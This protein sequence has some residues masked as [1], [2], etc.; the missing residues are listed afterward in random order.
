MPL[1]LGWVLL[2]PIVFPCRYCLDGYSC[3]PVCMHVLRF[4]NLRASIELQSV[5]PTYACLRMRMRASVCVCVPPYAYACLHSTY[6]A[7]NSILFKLKLTSVSTKLNPSLSLPRFAFLCLCL[8]LSLSLTH[9]LS[10]THSL[11][12]SL[13]HT[14]RCTLLLATG[15]RMRSSA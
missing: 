5:V 11:F 2:L 12:H 4:D 14:Q 7:A 3:S 6:L 15:M 1:L 8:S 9:L 13:S 10:H